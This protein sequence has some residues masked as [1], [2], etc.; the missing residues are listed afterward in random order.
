MSAKWPPSHEIQTEKKV[1][2]NDADKNKK[3]CV[4][5]YENSG[6]SHVKERTINRKDKVIN[7]KLH[8]I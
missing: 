5:S 7:L 4:L 2:N 6:N 3:W 1:V 8:Y